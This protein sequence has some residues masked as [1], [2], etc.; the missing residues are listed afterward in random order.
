MNR[1]N[2]GAVAGREQAHLFE[3]VCVQQDPAKLNDLGRVLCNV[4][5]MFIA[6]GSHVNNDVAVDTEL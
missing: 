4:D 2:A 1:Q 3:S 6:S 5:T